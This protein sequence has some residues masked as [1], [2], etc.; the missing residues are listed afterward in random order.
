MRD[1]IVV[2]NWK[3]NKDFEETEKMLKQLK[4]YSKSPSVKMMIAPSF[5]QLYQSVQLLKSTNIC[6]AAQN[7]GIAESGAYIGE[8]SA[9]ML[10]GIEQYSYYSSQF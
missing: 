6:V 7:I 3:M 8:V 2:G 1:R 4:S 9:K 10:K 5:T